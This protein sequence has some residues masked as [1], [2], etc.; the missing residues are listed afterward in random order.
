MS[1]FRNRR[2]VVRPATVTSIHLSRLS[3]PAPQSAIRS[4]PTN[5]D[6]FDEP[7]TPLL[8]RGTRRP[9][10]YPRVQS[11][12]PGAAQTW[13]RESSPPPLLRPPSGSWPPTP[14]GCSA[15]GSPPACAWAC[16]APRSRSSRYLSC[17]RLAR[18]GRRRRRAAL[19]LPT[20]RLQRL[21]ALVRRRQRRSA[22]GRARTAPGLD[23]AEEKK[24][25]PMSALMM[26]C[27]PNGKDKHGTRTTHSLPVPLP[28]AAA[29]VPRPR[30]RPR[31]C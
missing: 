31:R 7:P 22:V 13:A 19:T 26:I 18:A 11:R 1:A 4:K 2:E 3:L 12:S 28:A 10:V 20:A 6:A 16:S 17:S 21:E 29:A 27:L 9:D 24:Q 5:D 14:P 30:P 25:K 23:R 8:S 15:G